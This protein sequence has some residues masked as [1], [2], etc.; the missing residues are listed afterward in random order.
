MQIRVVRAPNVKRIRGCIDVSYKSPSTPEMGKALAV[1][2][3]TAHNVMVNGFLELGRTSYGTVEVKLK[4][5]GLL[6]CQLC[7]EVDQKL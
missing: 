4:H 5:T 1:S 3:V 6:S 7:C 2:N